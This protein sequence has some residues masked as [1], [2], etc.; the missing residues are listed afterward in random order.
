MSIQFP[1]STASS[2]VT[3]PSSDDSLAIDIGSGR[4]IVHSPGRRLWVNEPTLVGRDPD[5]RVI[6]TGRRALASD[7]RAGGTQVRL[8]QRGRVLDPAGCVRLLSDILGRFGLESPAS[9]RLAVPVNAT[10]YDISVLCSVVF[11]AIGSVPRPVPSLLAGAVGAGVTSERPVLIADFGVGLFEVGL[12]FAD[13]LL[14]DAAVEIGAQDFRRYPVD[15]VASAAH[16]VDE[17]V[18]STPG[19][20]DTLAAAPVHLIGGEARTKRFAERLAAR[21]GRRVIVHGD[22]GYA[23]ASG[24]LRLAKPAPWRAAS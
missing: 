16:A 5:G 22:A 21:S 17:V 10:P 15:A 6:G 14:S 9:V 19:A 20:R 18:A 11:S 23:V 3:A 2:G 7:V 4:I 1:M 24:L 12:V 13:Q 8:V